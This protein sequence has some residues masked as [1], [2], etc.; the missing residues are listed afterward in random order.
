MIWKLLAAASAALL[1]TTAFGAPALPIDWQISPAADGRVQLSLETREDGGRSVNSWPVAAADLA[2]LDPALLSA[3]GPVPVRFTYRREAGEIACQGQL[4]RRRGSG[5]CRFAPDA[6]FA[7]VL[8][9]RGIARP[10]RRQAYQLTIAGVGIG[11]VDELKRQ[12]YATPRVDDLV[13]A[14]IHGVTLPYVRAMAAAGYR[15]GTIDRLVAFRIHGVSADYVRALATASPGLSRM[16][17]DALVAMRIHGVT[18][19]WVG[20]L[21]R[22][23]YRDLTAEQL[24]AMRIHGVSADFVRSVQSAGRGRPSPEDLVAMRIIGG[25]SAGRPR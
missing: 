18:P 13:A 17:P 7:E 22:L 12:G 1:P 5:E 3:A 10:D 14:G 21:A 2:G 25:R 8:A 4:A 23:G 9:A 16:A 11:L 6:G 24:V 19:G 15:V 20:D